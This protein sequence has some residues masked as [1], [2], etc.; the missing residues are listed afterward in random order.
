MLVDVIG[1]AMGFVL[2]AVGG[3]VAIA[4]VPSVWLFVCTFTL[5]MFMGFCKRYNEL[6]TIGEPDQAA[7]HRPTLA[8]Y[9]PELLTHLI[10]LSAGVAVV[11][12]LLYAASPGTGQTFHTMLLVYTLP[13]VCYGVFRFAMLSM[14]GRYTD[15][16]DLM[17]RDRPFQLT[18]LLWL[19]SAAAVMQWGPQLLAWAW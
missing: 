1:I 14:M 4:V 3:A 8:G 2:R 15:P 16:T 10:T 5:C 17:L 18:L 12:F 7:A 9:S 11:A 13:L 19:A 6:I